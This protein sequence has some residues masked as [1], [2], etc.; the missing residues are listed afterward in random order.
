MRN[1]DV[2]LYEKSALLFFFVFNFPR[3]IFCCIITHFAEH[4]KTNY[5]KVM[6]LKLDQRNLLYFHHGKKCSL[7]KCV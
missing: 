4:S 5:Y 2:L 6:L 3:P 7:D 1:K